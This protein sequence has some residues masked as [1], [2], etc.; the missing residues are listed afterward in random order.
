[1][2]RL[3]YIVAPRALI[4]ELRVIRHAM[5]RHSTAPARCSFTSVRT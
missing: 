5:V 3:G 2:L 1:M 4:E